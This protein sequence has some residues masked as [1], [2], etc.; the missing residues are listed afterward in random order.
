M[1]I[2]KQFALEE[3]RTKV[4]CWPLK[5]NG[6][7]ESDVRNAIEMQEQRLANIAHMRHSN[8][9]RSILFIFGHTY[10]GTKTN[11]IGKEN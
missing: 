10:A 5:N 4:A 3:L 2:V 9:Y 6:W 7:A 8:T 1:T 11:Y